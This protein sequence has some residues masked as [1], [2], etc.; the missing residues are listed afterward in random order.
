MPAHVSTYSGGMDR[1]SS[2]NKYQPNSYYLMKNMRITSFEELSNGVVQSMNGNTIAIEAPY[3]QVN[4]YII[5]HCV[6]RNYLVVWST[7]CH[8]DIGGRGTIWRTDLSVDA[9]SWTIV[10]RHVDLKLSTKYPIADEAIGYYEDGEI[11][12]VYWTDNHNM[13]RYINIVDTSIYN[14]ISDTGI[15]PSLLDILPKVDF[16]TPLVTNISSGNLPVGKIQYAYQYYMLNGVETTYSQ[17]TPLVHITKTSER[18]TGENVVT[19]EGSPA[20]DSSGNPNNSGKAITIKIDGLD[21]D[22]DKIRIVAIIYRNLNQEPD[23]YIVGEYNVTSS[24]YI[25]DFGTYSKG[26]LT[27]NAFRTLGNH[28]LYCK[29]ISQKGSKAVIGNITEKFF[30]IDFDARAYRYAP[31]QPGSSTALISTPITL[32]AWDL[33]QIDYA[34]TTHTDLRIQIA[35]PAEAAAKNMDSMGIPGTVTHLKLEYEETVTANA[36]GEVWGKW[37]VDGGLTYIY[38][39]DTEI[40]VHITGVQAWA[41]TQ[42]GFDSTCTVDDILAFLGDVYIS[43][44]Y[45]DTLGTHDISFNGF[46]TGSNIIYAGNNLSFLI[47][48]TGG[49]FFTNFNAFESFTGLVQFAI[50]YDYNK[51][52]NY[53]YESSTATDFDYTRITIANDAPSWSFNIHKITDAWFSL[54]NPF[55]PTNITSVDVSVDTIYWYMPPLVPLPYIKVYDLKTDTEDY[56]STNVTEP[57]HAWPDTDYVIDGVSVPEDHDCINP[58]NYD[59]R[60]GHIVDGGT[61]LD[62]RVD[63]VATYW[64]SSDFITNNPVTNEPYTANQF[65]YQSDLSTLGGEGPNVKFEFVYEDIHFNKSTDTRYDEPESILISD[66]NSYDSYK[67]PLRSAYLLG[68]KRDEIYR[69]GLVA[70]NTRG[71]ESFVKWIADIKFPTIKEV[72]LAFG[73]A[74][75]SYAR[76]LGIKFTIDTTDL[77]DQDVVAVKIVRVERTDKDRTI[78]TQGLI[79][80]MMKDEYSIPHRISAY[81]RVIAK[82]PSLGVAPSYTLQDDAIQLIS[83]EISYFKDLNPINPDYIKLQAKIGGGVDGRYVYINK[84]PYSDASAVDISNL[85]EVNHYNAEGYDG[86]SWATFSR[87]TATSSIDNLIC[88]TIKDG[89]IAGPVEYLGEDENL[90]TLSSSVLPLLNRAYDYVGS[91]ISH[92]GMCSTCSVMIVDP[93]IDSSILTDPDECET[94]L[95]DYKINGR[96]TSQYGGMTYQARQQNVYIDCSEYIAVVPGTIDT[97]K[98]FGGDTYIS[99]FEHIKTI[100]ESDDND[101]DGT[102]DVSRLKRIMHVVSFPCETH[103][104]LDLDYGA[105]YSKNFKNKEIYALRETKGEYFTAYYTDLIANVIYKLIQGDDMYQYNSV[106][107]QQNNTKLYF[108]KP[109]EWKD[110]VAQD[111]LVKISLEK[112]PS[113]QID[114]YLKYLT[115]NERILPTEFGQ[116]NDLFLFKNYMI[117]FFDKAFGTLS[118]DERAVLPVQNNS[119]LELGSATNLQHF[120]FISNR[121]GSIHPQSID[122]CGNG[123]VWYDAISGSLGYYNGETTDLGLAKGMSSVLKR[124]TARIKNNGE[125]IMNSLHGGNVMCYENQAYKETLCAFTISHTAE[126]SNKTATHV[127]LTIDSSESPG[128]TETLYNTPIVI[129]G[130]D[131]SYEVI[132]ESVTSTVVVINRLINSHVDFSTAAWGAG[133]SYFIYYKDLS[134]VYSFSSITNSFMYEADIYPTWFIEY[135]GGIYDVFGK[136]DIWKENEGNYGMF[137]NIYREGIIDYLINPKG[138]LVCLFNNYEYAMEAY[139]D[140]NE[141]LTST[142]WNSI[143]CWNDYQYSASAGYRC[144]FTSINNYI[145]RSPPDPHELET[146]DLVSFSGSSLPANIEIDRYY[147]VYRVDDTNFMITEE[148]NS[149]TPIILTDTIDGANNYIH[150]LDVPLSTVIEPVND[151][152][153]FRTWRIKDLRDYRGYIANNLKPRL[154]DS[155]LRVMFKYMHGDNKRILM[156]DLITYFTA[157]RETIANNNRNR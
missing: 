96:V 5:G 119:I 9:P 127:T 100:W 17:C 44:T 113:E 61:G 69:F 20:L 42:P 129:F 58:Y 146:G 38:I 41:L 27:L 118:I 79:S 12:K 45:E 26:T 112:Y 23:I 125:Y 14:A 154:R 90:I 123:F 51:T 122:Y 40:E 53:V 62:P 131:A 117:V 15:D 104:N 93:A 107:S 60:Y 132:A 47:T 18:L 24:L 102:I 144:L 84:V 49:N 94:F 43:G 4:D 21:E 6:I 10:Y 76:V 143:R 72:N 30:D 34:N 55:D 95:V 137:Y 106:Y 2:K 157:P 50:N 105:T 138:S 54:I 35:T 133:I 115:D 31:R 86:N 57:G 99:F 56:I 92:E 7:A 148:R 88:H 128:R 13:I 140:D 29:T 141:N 85:L 78:Y 153:R 110:T 3:G 81:T 11:V 150:V 130:Y 19:Y 89:I 142:T 32:T 121:S 139:N 70:I 28:E 64:D 136:F 68:Y 111:T 151:K 46:G 147:Y 101:G 155:Y 52:Y 120:D 39:S 87:Y 73:I 67:N 1:D 77:I 83:P 36:N 135:N 108:S 22:Y 75:N 124:Y 71:Q 66:L 126:Y 33:L 134:S 97:D 16:V 63:E 91:T 98:M 114:A 8:D 145:R 149:I 25:T 37:R 65:K 156:H 103:I 116:I 48:S 74:R 80:N 109:E 152:R 59:F 82:T